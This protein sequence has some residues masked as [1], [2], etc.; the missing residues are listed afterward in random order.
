MNTLY[1]EDLEIG[2]TFRSPA[3]TV[4]EADL[5]IFSMVSGDWNPIHSDAEFARRTPYGERIVHGTL[6]IAIV[7]GMF[8]RL[9]I[10]EES[11]LAL[12]GI[13]EWRFRAPIL[14]GDTIHMELEIAEKRLT[15]KGD[16]GII[17]RRIRL[18]RHDGTVLQD[19]RMG[20]M[21]KLRPTA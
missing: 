20:M 9:G 1:Y 14:V 10:F 12:L 2:Q 3:R 4:T 21:I 6:G 18:V 8:D 16:R 17:D 11:A 19:G 5:T 15:S 7:T 13:D